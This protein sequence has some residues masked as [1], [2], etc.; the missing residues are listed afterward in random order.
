MTLLS[1]LRLAGAALCATVFLAACQS[2]QTSSPA[3]TAATTPSGYF[4]APETGV[5]TG[6][7]HHYPQGQVQRLDQA[8]RQ[9]PED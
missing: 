3:G 8:L 5:K 2:G 4:P 7:F 1:T 6:Y 9:Q